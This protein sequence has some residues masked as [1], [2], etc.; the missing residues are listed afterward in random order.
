MVVVAFVVGDYDGVVAVAPECRIGN[1]SQPVAQGTRRQVLILGVEWIAAVEAVRRIALLI[2]AFIG[3]DVAECRDVI[4]GQVVL[5]LFNRNLAG[6]R[7]CLQVRL[8]G[9][10]GLIQLCSE[11]G[12]QPELLGERVEVRRGGIDSDSPPPKT[13]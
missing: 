5:Q 9:N 6:I 3:N 1:L 8:P 2:V 13:D 11:I 7:Q 10:A 4:A 12:C